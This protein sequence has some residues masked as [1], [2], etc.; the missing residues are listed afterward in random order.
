MAHNDEKARKLD[1]LGNR[2]HPEQYPTDEESLFDRFESEQNVDAIPME[3]LKM[4][5]REEK[6]GEETKHQSSSENK[7]KPQV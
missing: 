2:D 6:H 4:E 3:D 1:Q 7:Y 5:Q